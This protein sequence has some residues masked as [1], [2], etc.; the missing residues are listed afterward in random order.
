MIQCCLHTDHLLI[1]QF[2]HFNHVLSIHLLICLLYPSGH[3]YKSKCF[4]SFC[5]ALILM[6]TCHMLGSLKCCSSGF[7][8]KKTAKTIFSVI[9][10]I[11]LKLTHYGLFNIVFI[12]VLVSP[13]SA[14][15]RLLCLS[16]VINI[17]C[18]NLFDGSI[19]YCNNVTDMMKIN[20]KAKSMHQWLFC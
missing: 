15:F 20:A 14:L 4:L 11:S 13:S 17:Y 18:L 10:L 19:T 5:S 8:W 2:Y 12:H 7:S 1:S 3:T 9:N 16:A 6:S